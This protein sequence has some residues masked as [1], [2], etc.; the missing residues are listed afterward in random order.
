[1]LAVRLRVVALATTSFLIAALVVGADPAIAVRATT[2]P[3]I[4][5]PPDV[6]VGE[7]DGH[8]DLPVTLSAPSASTVSVHYTTANST[9]VAPLC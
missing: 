9:A 1:M 5:A 7:G 6:V 3:G 2:G 4:S 8:V